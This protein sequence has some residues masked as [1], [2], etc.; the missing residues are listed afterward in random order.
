MHATNK[1]TA[2]S[3]CVY[4]VILIHACRLYTLWFAGTRFVSSYKIFTVSNNI[5]KL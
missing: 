2:L 1:I 3:S 4:Y 5:G